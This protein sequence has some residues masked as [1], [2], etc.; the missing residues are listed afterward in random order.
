MK[1]SLI[2]LGL[3]S[4]SFFCI[5]NSYAAVYYVDKVSGSDTN[6]GLTQNSAWQTV[7]KVGYYSYHIRFNP[8][9]Q[10]LFKSGQ[11]WDEN[12]WFHSSGTPAAHIIISSYDA[13]SKP[14]I[15]GGMRFTTRQSFIEIKNIKSNAFV[16]S[17]TYN[18]LRIAGGHDFL[19]EGCDLDGKN[20]AIYNTAFEGL[21]TDYT[22]N[23][24]IKDTNVYNGGLIAGKYGGGLLFNRGARNILI[25]NCN[26]F[27]NEE[28]N[29]Q[30][31]SDDALMPSHSLTVKRTKVY[32]TWGLDRGGGINIGWG[33][34]NCVIDKSYIKDCKDNV[35]FDSNTR[36][37]TVKNSVI[38]DGVQ[39]VTILSNSYGD[40]LRT[41]VFNNTIIGTR[42]DSVYGIRTLY[43]SGLNDD[44]QFADNIFYSTY[45]WYQPFHIDS[46]TTNIQSDY[47]DFFIASGFTD[48]EFH[49]L[50]TTYNGLAAFRAASN[51]D[52]HSF[53][54]DPRFINSSY[55]ISSNSP[56]KDKGIALPG[57]VDDILGISRPQGLG[58]DI[59]AY[60]L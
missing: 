54:R 20:L 53:N 8:G 46:G 42:A 13:G 29:I 35:S 44:H 31:Y 43:Y 58:Y 49:Y 51:L 10:I 24:W 33:A 57:A 6:D 14:D 28:V 45:R 12:L 4:L 21:G 59:G 15:K 38:K 27:N 23:I 56:C 9:D 37:N 19:I 52:L 47:N 17:S 2:F 22:Y 60:E 1:K 26:V 39:N 11:S 41:R 25:E 34:Y 50:G 5:L 3:Y 55:K 16:G 30:I 32:N 18:S 40:N 48:L 7:Y 36:D